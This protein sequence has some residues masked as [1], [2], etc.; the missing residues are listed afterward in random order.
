MHAHTIRPV[1]VAT[2]LALAV[3]GCGR[4]PAP[5]TPSATASAPASATAPTESVMPTVREAPPIPASANQDAATATAQTFAEMW[6]AFSPANP[7]A[8]TYWA[9]SW[10][11]WATSEFT[12][13]QKKQAQNTWSWTWN[14]GVKTCCATFPA[15]P[16]TTVSGNTATVVVPITWWEMP[17]LAT[18]R[19]IEEGA[20]KETAAT[21]T[22]ELV[23]RNDQWRVA[24]AI[25][26]PTGGDA[27]RGE[28]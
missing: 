17:L 16:T 2:C 21:V 9:N 18:Q 28:N 11:Q 19:E 15:E 7:D 26:A 8:L 4:E 25:V 5:E 3:S 12:Q 20:G 22:V 23:A 27:G 1:A 6:V 14:R 10:S 13:E 24:N